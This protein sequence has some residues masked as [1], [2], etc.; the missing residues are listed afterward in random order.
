[1]PA[2]ELPDLRLVVAVTVHDERQAPG[3]PLPEVP[4]EVVPKPR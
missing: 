2:G 1:L 3:G 4:V